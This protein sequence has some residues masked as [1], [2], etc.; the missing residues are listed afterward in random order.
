MMLDP[1]SGVLSLLNPRSALTTRLELGGDW[2]LAFPAYE[3]IKFNVIQQGQCWLQVDGVDEPL[4]L[5][6]GDGYLLTDGRPYL[7]YSQP[8]LPPRDARE[9]LNHSDE[10]V[11]RTW[12]CCA[13][14]S[15]STRPI[16]RC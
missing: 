1:L 7:L 15:P 12:W 3:G 14:S 2:C 16:R 10:G 5:Q 11:V 13:A 6:A 4:Q 8:R 9:L